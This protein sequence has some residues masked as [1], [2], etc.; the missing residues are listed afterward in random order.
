MAFGLPAKHFS[1]AG[2]AGFQWTKLFKCF[3]NYETS[4]NKMMSQGLLQSGMGW[5]HGETSRPSR[6]SIE[7]SE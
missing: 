2:F 5:V 4:G 3:L 7:I 6:C 1:P